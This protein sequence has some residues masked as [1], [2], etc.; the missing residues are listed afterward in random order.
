M[1]VGTKGVVGYGLKL[2]TIGFVSLKYHDRV[3]LCVNKWHEMLAE[4]KQKNNRD[5]HGNPYVFIFK[6]GG[7][8]GLT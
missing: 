2:T 1:V 3:H 6:A 5:R 7:H 8:K 4:C